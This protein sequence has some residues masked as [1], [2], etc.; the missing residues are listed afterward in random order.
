M[1]RDEALRRN[2]RRLA[3]VEVVRAAK[4]DD[5]A[6]HMLEVQLVCELQHVLGP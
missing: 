2:T 6:G 4:V 5:R 1:E 3:G